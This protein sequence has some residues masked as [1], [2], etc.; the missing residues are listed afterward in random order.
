MYVLELALEMP[1]KCHVNTEHVLYWKLSMKS[2]S[3]GFKNH[4]VNS[5]HVHIKR[6]VLPSFFGTHPASITN[7]RI[8]STR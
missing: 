3:N 1:E 5:T 7:L 8:C 4:L 2:V 6:G